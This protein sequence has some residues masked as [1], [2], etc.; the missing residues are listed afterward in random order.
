LC[1]VRINNI[2]DSSLNLGTY[3]EL[4]VYI[5]QKPQVEDLTPSAAMKEMR[6]VKK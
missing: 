1:E 5:I 4:N 2:D 3:P 6:F